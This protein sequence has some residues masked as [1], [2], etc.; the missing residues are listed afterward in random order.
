MDFYFCSLS[1]LL[2]LEFCVYLRNSLLFIAIFV[3]VLI[4]MRNKGDRNEFKEL[5]DKEVIQAYRHVLAV[6]GG[7]VDVM[8]IYRMVASAPASRFFVSARQAYR[9]LVRLRRGGN[10][11]GMRR[12]NQR[13]YSEIFKRVETEMAAGQAKPQAL[14]KAI[15]RVVE[16]P[17]PEMYLGIRQVAHIIKNGGRKCFEER[18]L[19]WSR[20]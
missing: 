7:K 11:E 17:A 13:M 8:T 4:V 15:A 14:M 10:L 5:R 1:Y 6:Y 12:V 3:D 19:R 18:K 20:S 9:V 16:Q 2:F